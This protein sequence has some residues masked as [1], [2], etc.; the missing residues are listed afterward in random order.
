MPFCMEPFNQIARE[1]LS[2]GIRSNS[3]RWA[4]VLKAISK[5]EWLKA[6]ET[7]SSEKW[8]VICETEVPSGLRIVKRGP[9]CTLRKCNTTR[10]KG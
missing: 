8:G 6:I 5:Q 1:R 3:A 7:W 4:L 9:L 2:A 10:F